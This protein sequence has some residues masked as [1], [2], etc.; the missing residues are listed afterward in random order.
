MN[1]LWSG[2]LLLIAMFCKVEGDFAYEEYK[3]KRGNILYLVAI[4]C[5]ILAILC[6]L[7]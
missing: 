1:W 4:I 3:N 6:I 2:I 7:L 5:N